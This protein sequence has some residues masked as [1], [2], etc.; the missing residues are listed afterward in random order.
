MAMFSKKISKIDDSASALIKDLLGEDSSKLLTVHSY[1]H[2]QGSYIFLQF[3]KIDSIQSILAQNMYT[4]PSERLSV[5][6]D[7]VDR[8][9]GKLILVFFDNDKSVFFRFRVSE[10]QGNVFISDETIE[11]DFYQLQSWF[12]SLNAK[13]LQD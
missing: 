7:F 6:W 13:I 1:Y 4:D 8:A 3:V 11:C 10:M 12:Q 9:K 5:V 2:Y